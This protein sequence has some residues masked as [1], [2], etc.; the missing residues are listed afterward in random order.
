MLYNEAIK[1]CRDLEP[2]DL[3]YDFFIKFTFSSNKIENNQTRLI[4]V[5]TIFYG[6]TTGNYKG[7]DKT[8]KE[9]ENHRDL[10]NRLVEIIR[11]NNGKISVELIRDIHYYLAKDCLSENLLDR[12]ERPGEFKKDYY[13][14]GVHDIG[15]RPSE[16]EDSLRFIIDEVNNIEINEDNAIKVISYL[17]CY[18]EAIHPF[19]DFNGRVGRLLINYI[20]IANKLPPIIIFES[21]RKEYYL[22]LEYFNETQEIDKMVDFLDFEEY[23]T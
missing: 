19:C 4:D 14:V 21:D 7:Y 9:I 22:A 20:L 8:I 10:C 11:E 2:K 16:V 5:K 12:G 6:Q 15:V 13:V 1:I 17:H 3:L 18:F 23:K